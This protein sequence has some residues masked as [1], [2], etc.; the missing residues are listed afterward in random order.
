M[1]GLGEL[2][3]PPPVSPVTTK[4]PGGRARRNS[5]PTAEKHHS[6]GKR[7]AFR[8]RLLGARKTEP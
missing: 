7:Q 2:L 8:E 1:D 5:A 6:N 4:P 3:E